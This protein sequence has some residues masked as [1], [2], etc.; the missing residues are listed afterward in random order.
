MNEILLAAWTLGQVDLS[1]EFVEQL[2]EEVCM[3][4]NESDTEAPY[5]I[6]IISVADFDQK[7]EIRELAFI[8]LH[9]AMDELIKD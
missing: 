1:P 7:D 4:H 2:A 8:A 9:H 3:D 6:R 5:F